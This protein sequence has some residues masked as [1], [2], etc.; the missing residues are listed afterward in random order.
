MMIILFRFT[1][2]FTRKQII[3]SGLPFMSLIKLL[4]YSFLFCYACIFCSI[5]FWLMCLI[6]STTLLL[7]ANCNYSLFVVIFVVILCCLPSGVGFLINPCLKGNLPVN[8]VA[9][10]GAQ[11]GVGT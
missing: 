10:E 9:L 11:Y 8:S 1:I 2:N 7:G 4:D 6:L 5:M 3:V